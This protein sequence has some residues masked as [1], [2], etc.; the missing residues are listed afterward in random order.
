[1]FAK[2]S[3]LAPGLLAGSLVA[4]ALVP[5]PVGA[6]R[7]GLRPGARSAQ[8]TR[9]TTVRVSPSEDAETRGLAR[10]TTRFAI[11]EVRESG[12]RCG[13]W[14]SV[15]VDAWVCGA[16]LASSSA[17]PSGRAFPE[18]RR[19]RA[20][21]YRYA[22][23][24]RDGA[25]GWLEREA[26]GRG[27]PSK[28]Y[29]GGFMFV[30]TLLRPEPDGRRLVRMRDGH[31]VDRERLQVYYESRFAG[32]ELAS[33]DELSRL[34]W[35]IPRRRG[36]ERRSSTEVLGPDGTPTRRELRRLSR[37]DVRAE[38]G[39]RLEI[40]AGVF[41][42]AADVRRPGLVP[43]PEGIEA[44][45]RWVHVDRG[46]QTLVAYEG[47]R[48]VFAT[49]VSSGQPR[50]D[51]ETPAGDFRLWIKI[52]AA[53]MDDTGNEDPGEDYSVES[54]PWVQYFEGSNGFHAAFWHQSFGRPVSH[55][56]VNMS[57]IDARWLFG[58]TRPVLPDGWWS[59]RPT[60]GDP[61][62]RIVVR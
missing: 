25:D 11:G 35:V 7:A 46:T 24:L 33:A 51:R 44:D 13:F 36:G 54:V 48:P 40:A 55:G 18:V 26:F 2:R 53:D 59:I 42:D 22:R 58:F 57:P 39:D 27:S 1:M 47:A 52:A 29:R 61:A 23:V 56:C 62:T 10:A 32:V 17:A 6:Q 15:G 45:E 5:P 20:L 30:A 49:L 38:A 43:P 12:D 37:V 4:L 60:A 21:P 3:R 19:G 14:M 9:G 50:Q 41:V 8:L 34:G 28:S 16:H 31:F